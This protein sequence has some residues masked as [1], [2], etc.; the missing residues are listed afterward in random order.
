MSD[1]DLLS[2]KNPNLPV[3]TL[4]ALVQDG[5]RYVRDAVARNPNTPVETLVTLAQ[6]Q[7]E[8]VRA[9]VASNPNYLQGGQ[10]SD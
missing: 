4:V 2:A 10:D 7:D 6:D 8:H 9:A 1:E 5:P 3:E